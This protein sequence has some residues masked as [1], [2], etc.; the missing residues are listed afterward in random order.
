V[1]C[2]KAKSFIAGFADKRDIADSES[3]AR[4]RGWTLKAMKAE[5][6]KLAAD[7]AGSVCKDGAIEMHL[8]GT[9]GA[10]II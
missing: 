4:Y 10:G 2:F 9:T 7:L 1:F 3:N 6:D 5:R 8:H